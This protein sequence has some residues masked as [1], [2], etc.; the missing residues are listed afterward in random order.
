[1][2]IYC[3]IRPFIKDNVLKIRKKNRGEASLI[4]NWKEIKLSAKGNECESKPEKVNECICAA[5]SSL[6]INK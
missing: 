1:M 5:S 4:L 2:Q 6:F 3:L